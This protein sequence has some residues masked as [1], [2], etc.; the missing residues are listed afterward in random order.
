MNE[1]SIG[2]VAKRS[3]LA[4]SAIR[5]YESVGVVPKP[6]RSNGRRVYDERWMK[7][8]ALVVLAQEG[9]F[10]I[11]ETKQIVQQFSNTKS[12]P[13]KRWKKAAQAKLN[14]LE[15]QRR[16][17]DQMQQI[18][19]MSMQCRCPSIEDCADFAV[20]HLEE[21][22]PENRVNSLPGSDCR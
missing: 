12:P 21:R 4:A 18:L 9:G 3:G 6:A 20:R 13:S 19:K 15:R 10:S 2:E 17:I 7:W 16:R 5:Y 11:K 1:F 8:L 22:A 14:E